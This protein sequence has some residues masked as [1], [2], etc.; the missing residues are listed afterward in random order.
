MCITSCVIGDSRLCLECDFSDTVSSS[1]DG[2]AK[3][4]RICNVKIS[5]LERQR[6]RETE[7]ER[8]TDLI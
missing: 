3:R 5:C 2:T 7:R 1:F 8:Q 6:Q 4:I